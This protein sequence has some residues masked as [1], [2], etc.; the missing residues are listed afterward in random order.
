MTDDALPPLPAMPAPAALTARPV[1]PTPEAAPFTFTGRLGP[2]ALIALK[3]A[4]LTLLTLGIYRFW[5][6]TELRRYFWGQ[7]VIDGEALEYTGRGLELFLGFLVMIAILGPATLIYD[8]TLTAVGP[9]STAGG[10]LQ[11]AY[12]VG[13]LCL[14]YVAVYRIWRYRLSRTVWRGIRFGLEGSSVR[15]MFLALGWSALALVTLGIA[16][17]W[18]DRSLWAYRV[19]NMRFGTLRF[20][21]DRSVGVL[22][23]LGIWLLALLSPLLILGTF[24]AIAVRAQAGA[25]PDEMRLFLANYFATFGGWVVVGVAV[26]MVCVTWYQVAR[27]RLL[28]GGVR[29]GDGGAALKS[30]ARLLVVLGI[31]LLYWL[32][33][34]AVAGLFAYLAYITLDPY[35]THGGM[36]TGGKLAGG[37]LFAIL[38]VMVTVVMPILNTLV[39]DYGLTAHFA[40]TLSVTNP[41]ALHAALQEADQGPK[42]GEGLADAFD[43]GAF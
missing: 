14:I 27:F 42:R 25:A 35:M 23:L 6:K 36:A 38:F 30:R 37:A 18:M 11:L 13:V 8:W 41:A 21:F 16:M 20:G 2:L 28:V 17:P 15:Y 22:R 3:N 40:R 12:T 24:A 31:T 39:L 19:D 10:I 5:A 7:T 33:L 43:V 9:L 4:L 29:V 1:A 34:A 32:S 26:W